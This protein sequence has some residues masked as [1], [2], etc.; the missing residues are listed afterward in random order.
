[1]NQTTEERHDYTLT[2]IQKIYNQAL[3]DLISISSEIHRKSQT[4]NNIHKNTLVSYKTGGCQEDCAYCAQ[5]S[6]YQT[7][8]ESKSVY[9]SV[10]EAIKQAKSAKD[11]GAK[12][13]C[14]SASWRGIPNEQKLN[15]I[16]EIGKG[17]KKLGLEVCCT[18]GKVN[19][20]QLEQLKKIG[21]SAYNHN[22]DTSREF[23]PKIS[24]SRTYED[25][26]H[27]LQLLQEHDMPYCSGG[28]IGMGESI[29]D[30][31][32]M[33]M[34]LVN[35]KKHPYS[36]PL[37]IL[38]PIQGTPLQN[39]PSASH[40]EMVRLIAT[41]RILMPNTIICLAAGRQNLSTEAQILCFL[42]GAN[43]IFVGEKLLTTDNCSLSADAEL[44]SLLNLNT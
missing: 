10:E 20:E 41:A 39:M 16:I 25:R 17:V 19:H 28:I 2:E 36:L 37:N 30:R 14:I 44:F 8:I 34:T 22:I 27:T 43:S 13:I 26:L 31:L 42:A 3:L 40:W 33:L 6:R 35:Q 1:M 12:R 32:C 29:D 18:L 7:H 4:Y 5:S 23:F 15:E 24:T 38:V 9:L 21:F 11:A